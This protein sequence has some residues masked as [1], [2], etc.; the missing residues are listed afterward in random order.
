MRPDRPL[1][2]LLSLLL[3]AGCATGRLVWNHRS[4]VN[5]VDAFN[6]DRYVCVQESRTQAAGG[7]VGRYALLYQAAAQIDAQNQANQLFALCMQAH[8]WVGSRVQP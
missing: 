2:L 7:F 3:L 5:D 4:G 8:G 1:L 6:R